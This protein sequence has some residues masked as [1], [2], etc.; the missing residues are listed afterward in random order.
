VEAFARVLLVPGKRR[1]WFLLLSAEGAFFVLSG[2]CLLLAE[3]GV[4]GS[5]AVD[6]LAPLFFVVAVLALILVQWI[7]LRVAPLTHAEREAARGEIPQVIDSL[8][9]APFAFRP[10]AGSTEDP[11]APAREP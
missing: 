8:A 4:V 10:E 5:Y 7:G 1:T 11:R 3:V 2:L 6:V 9:L